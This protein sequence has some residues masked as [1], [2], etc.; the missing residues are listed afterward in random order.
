MYCPID[1][2]LFDEFAGA[3]ESYFSAVRQLS[4]VTAGIQTGG[5]SFDEAYRRARQEYEKCKCALQAV[6]EHR[7]EHH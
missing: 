6:E 3:T 5:P 2:R 1:D 7:S 4:A